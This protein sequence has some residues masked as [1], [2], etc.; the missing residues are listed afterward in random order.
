MSE[1]VETGIRGLRLDVGDHVCALY[2]GSSDR[3]ALLMPYLSTGLDAGDKGICIVDSPA[4]AAEVQ[5]L[6][7]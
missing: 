5:R 4:T 6:V 2:R 7:N 1:T 3:D